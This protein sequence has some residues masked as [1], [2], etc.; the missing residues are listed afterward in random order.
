MTSNDAPDDRAWAAIHGQD[1]ALEWQLAGDGRP[2]LPIE[3][4][5]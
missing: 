2:L 1:L 5:R 3:P 4:L